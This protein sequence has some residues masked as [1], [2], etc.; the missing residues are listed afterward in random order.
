MKIVKFENGQYGIRTHWFFGTR[1]LDLRNNI[2][3]WTQRS[4]FFCDC[5][6]DDLESCKKKVG[7]DKMKYQIYKE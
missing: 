2:Y 3:S 4:D 6:T 5:L 1:F 7:M